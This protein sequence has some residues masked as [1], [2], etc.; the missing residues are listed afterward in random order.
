MFVSCESVK[1]C[2]SLNFTPLA[3]GYSQADTGL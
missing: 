2:K 1:P 3:K